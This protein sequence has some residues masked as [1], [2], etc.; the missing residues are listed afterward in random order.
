[1]D[2]L[3][4]E[5]KQEQQFWKRFDDLIIWLR[6]TNAIDESRKQDIMADMIDRIDD[7]LFEMKFEE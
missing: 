3:T 5:T 7:H 6:K 4:M 1:M 2:N